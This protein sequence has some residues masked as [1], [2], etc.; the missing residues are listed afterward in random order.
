MS[1][2][3]ELLFFERENSL[4]ASVNSPLPK[5]LL[6][7]ASSIHR[8]LDG[9][10]YGRWFFFAESLAKVVDF[11]NDGTGSIEVEIGERRDSSFTV[12]IAPDSMQV[13]INTDPPYGGKKLDSDE[14]YMALGSAGITFGIDQTAVDSASA[15]G[16]HGRF[17]VAT[18]VPPTNGE[19]ARF[20][21]LVAEARD[22]APKVDDNG[23]IDFREQGAI[24]TVSAE[25]ALMRRIPPTTG[26]AGRTT[27]GEV[28]EPTPGGDAR[29]S[30]KLIGS[31]VDRDDANLLRA[32][33][34]GQPVCIANG[35]NVE[36]VLSVRNVNMATGNISFDGT[37]KIDGEV[38]AGM[39]VN[40]TGDIIVSGVVDG[41][42]LTASGDIRVGGGIIAKARVC[43]GGSVTARFVENAHVVAGTTIAVE[44]TVLQSDLQA[45]N[46]ILV[47]TKSTQRGRLAGGSARA[48]M[49]IHTPILGSSSGGL[50]SVLVGVNPVLEAL[51]HDL[52]H[53]IDRLR[54]EEQNLEKLVKHLTKQGDKAGLL[55]RAKLS[56]QQAIKAWG[57]LLPE[58]D[59]LERQLAL[60]AGAK[61]QVSAGVAGPVDMTFGKK[62]SR[63]RRLYEA[64]SFSVEGD[65]V[66]FFDKAGNMTPAS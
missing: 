60:V 61:V 39:K 26:T 50:T 11:Y 40:V 13:W 62:V 44:D 30:E 35:V 46:Q 33:F 53:K 25:Q 14:I 3:P 7:D 18:G 37:V 43:A 23:L 51:H 2:Y 36:Q 1:E 41:A 5:R 63:L 22:R 17:L 48:M 54:E 42:E 57:R 66:L 15:A 64:G 21:L 28:L 16:E 24:P 10:G 20:E 55:D 38:M 12:E 49:L 56:W 4:I 34:S 59:E 45:N 19:N 29:F 27:R 52:L 6:L 8:L 31:F 65:R 32:Q 9:Y 47:G 58:R